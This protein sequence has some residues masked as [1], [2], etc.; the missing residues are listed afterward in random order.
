MNV[1]AAALLWLLV[2]FV[3]ANWPFLTEKR[4]F[5]FGKT[6]KAFWFRIVEMLVSYGLL[7]GFGWI[8]EASVGRV[9][10][11]TWNFYAITA[12]L[13][14]LMAYPGYVWRF[15]RRRPSA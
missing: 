8:L 2:G 9:Q 4:F 1:T 10:S 3:L 15:L 11:Q 14:V 12:L 6:P 7:L 13:F 5:V